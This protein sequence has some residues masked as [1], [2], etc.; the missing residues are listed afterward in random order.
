MEKQRIDHEDAVQNIQATTRADVKQLHL[1]IQEL[2]A[3]L[4][5][6]HANG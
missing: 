4:E 1:T 6:Q 2:R 5:K 3:R